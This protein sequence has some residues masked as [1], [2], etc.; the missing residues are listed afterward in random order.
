ML[1]HRRQTL[2][3]LLGRHVEGV[4]AAWAAV[5]IAGEL[6]VSAEREWEEGVGVRSDGEEGVGVSLSGDEVCC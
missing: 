5:M 6:S 3:A 2:G 4:A 1:P